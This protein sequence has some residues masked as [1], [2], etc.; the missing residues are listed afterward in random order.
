MV[1]DI[2][3][4]QVETHPSV[5][6]DIRKYLDYGIGTYIRHI[7]DG[8]HKLYPSFFFSL[9]VNPSHHFSELKR[10]SYPQIFFEHH[11][12]NPIQ[13]KISLKTQIFHAPHYISPCPENIPFVLTVHDL[14]HLDPPILP[15]KFPAIGSFSSRLFLNTKIQYHRVISRVLLLNRLNRSRKIICVSKHTAD[16][17]INRC[18]IS[19]RKICVIH[20]CIDSHYFENNTLAAGHL[21]FKKHGLEPKEYFLFSGNILLHKNAAALLEAW[22]I[23]KTLVP[24]LPKLVF[25]GV[26][27]STWLTHRVQQLGLS[28][29]VI[30]TPFLET[31]E[32]PY[33]YLG[34]L[35][36]ILPSLAEG[37]GLPA[38]EAMAIGTPVIC[39]N[40]PVLKEVTDNCAI[41]FDPY[42][43]M[44]IAQKIKF[45]LANKSIQAELTQNGVLIAQKYNLADF[46][47]AHHSIYQNILEEFHG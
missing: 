3:N 32:C 9:I 45:F 12:R 4:N 24:C 28:S 46:T 8:F 20:N 5:S 14:I 42:D 21:I 22:R 7:L 10:F 23:L 16:N 37:F 38:A 1:C 6:L 15:N 36:L 40:I 35:A 27:N 18:S 2:K 30:I 47:N 29:D 44:D 39:S 17:L 19:P 33:L 43:P 31:R 13:G 11:R 41:F 34:A 25:M 26:R